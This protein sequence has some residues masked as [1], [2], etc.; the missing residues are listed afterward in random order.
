MERKDGLGTETSRFHGM[1]ST[2]NYFSWTRTPPVFLRPDIDLRRESLE[3][4][5]AN[6]IIPR[7]EDLHSANDGQPQLAT[8]PRQEEI[9]EFGAI[10]MRPDFSPSV[11]YF[12]KMLEQGHSLQSLFLDFLEPTARHLGDLWHQD[13]CDFVDVAIGVTHLQQLLLTFGSKSE[14]PISGPHRRALLMTPACEQHSFGVYL[15]AEFMTAAG[16][17]VTTIHRIK[18]KDAAAEVAAGWFGIAGMSLSSESGLEATA[19]TINAIRHASLNSAIRV[20]VGGPTVM[21][22][23]ELAARVGA[24]AA[25]GDAPTAVLLAKKLLLASEV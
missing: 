14:C 25:A 2:P 10:V 17:D 9:E 6:V 7:L 20:F 5:V 19:R 12:E 18:V 4:V 11:A 21:Q 13:R 3:D 1:V 22:K 16:W 8:V 24:D 23:P 15:F